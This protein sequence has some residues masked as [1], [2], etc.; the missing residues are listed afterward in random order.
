MIV[1]Y[2]TGDWD[3]QSV[4]TMGLTDSIGGSKRTLIVERHPD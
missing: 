4:T 1:S 2:F 3:L